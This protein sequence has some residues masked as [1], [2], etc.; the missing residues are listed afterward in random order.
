[1]PGSL[2]FCKS[3]LFQFK[4]ENLFRIKAIKTLEKLAKKTSTKNKVNKVIAGV[5]QW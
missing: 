2:Q 4:V 5:Q 3:A 1:V